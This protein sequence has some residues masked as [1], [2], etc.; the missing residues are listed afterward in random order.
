MDT[1]KVGKQTLKIAIND[2]PSRVIEFNPNDILFV[3]KFYGLMRDF[4]SK[5]QSYLERAE[6]LDENQMMDKSGVPANLDERLAYLR[7]VCEFVHAGIDR[8]FGDGASKK[9]FQG[10]LDLSMIAEF[11]EGITPLIQKTRSDK[12]NQHIYKPAK[13]QKRV[14]K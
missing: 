8:V 5:E 7:E 10:Q 9:I 6:Q 12:I 4:E 13:S 2:D 11:F 1:I 14:L 3:E